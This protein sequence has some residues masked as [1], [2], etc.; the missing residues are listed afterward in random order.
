MSKRGVI[1]IQLCVLG[2]GAFLL[3]T[4][5]PIMEAT[6]GCACGFQRKWYEMPDSMWYGKR[7]FLRIDKV[8]NPAHTHRLWDAQWGVWVK[9]PWQE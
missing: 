8:G 1:I 3:L 9:L 2:M 5:F 7:L 6:D 4:C